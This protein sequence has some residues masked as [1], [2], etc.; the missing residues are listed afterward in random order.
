MMAVGLLERDDV[1]T[2]VEGLVRRAAAS[3]GGAI[4]IEA[5]AG[6]GKTAVLDE[7]RARSGEAGVLAARCVDLERDYPLGV[8]RQLLEPALRRA[9]PEDRARWLTGAAIAPGLLRGDA[10]AAV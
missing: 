10:A 7:V 2:L 4:L 8:A 1:L 3:A 9:S 5:A 6:M